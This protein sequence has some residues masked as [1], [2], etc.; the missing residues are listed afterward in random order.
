M[1]FSYVTQSSMRLCMLTPK[2]YL[3]YWFYRESERNYE[4]DEDDYE[5][6]Q[7]SNISVHRPKLVSFLFCTSSF[8]YM[9]LMCWCIILYNVV[10]L[11]QLLVHID[12][13]SKKFKRLK[14]ARR[15]E[16]GHSDFPEEEDFDESGKRGRTAE[17]KLKH[18]LFGDDEGKYHPTVL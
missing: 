1:S 15:D 8:P 10:A 14:K 9:E 12:Q 16:E 7:E 6:L 17:E 5:L 3:V 2:W 13:E 11:F 18:S 4:L